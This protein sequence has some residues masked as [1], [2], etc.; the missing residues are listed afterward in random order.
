MEL[1]QESPLR[2]VRGG[3]RLY[4][5][6][7]FQYL[8]QEPLQNFLQTRYFNGQRNETTSFNYETFIS[9]GSSLQTDYVDFLVIVNIPTQQNVI[10]APGVW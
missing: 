1:V 7:L 9:R 5:D 2:L 10:Y 3:R 6:N 8:E 4:D